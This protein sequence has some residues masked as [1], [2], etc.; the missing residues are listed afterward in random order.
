MRED[1]SK[2]IVERPRK[3][4]SNGVQAARRRDDFEGPQ[5]LGIRAGYGYRHLNE[6]LSPLRRYLHAQVG[7]PW[8]KVHGEIASRIDRRNT[9]QQHVY[10]HLDDFIAIQ[11]EVRGDRLIDLRHRYGWEGENSIRQALYVDPQ[12][13]LIRRN[14]H[15]RSRRRQRDEQRRLQEAE[16]RSRRR[17]ID[18]C[19]LLI[20][21]E[22]NWFE[23]RVEPL[24]AAQI[25]ETTVLGKVC[26]K[27]VPVRCFDVVRKLSTSLE[28]DDRERVRL[29]GSRSV[30][31]VAKRQLSR[32]E[33]KLHGLR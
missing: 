4:K 29:Y 24:P 7:R 8:N 6:N 2:V 16:T 5:F 14:K 19:R 9:V 28:Q 20:L 31:A 18:D 26:R 11:V 10:E 27:R 22:G 3:H 23:I 30:Y 25:V 13:G 17:V 12:T 32:R 21:L 15:H 33:L 1:M